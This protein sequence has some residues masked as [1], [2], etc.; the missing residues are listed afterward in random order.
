MSGIM[1]L[2]LGYQPSKWEKESQLTEKEKG[3]LKQNWIDFAQFVDAN[4]SISLKRNTFTIEGKNGSK[5]SFD[6]SME[7][8]IW[9]PPNTLER[10][11]NSLRAIRNGA[12][13]KSNL[14]VHMSISKHQK[15]SKIDT[16]I[17]MIWVL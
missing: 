14:G 10:Y 2:S 16:G 1:L 6:A 3:N 17:R 7:F 5:F 12:R 15:N 13:R 9:L 4:D 11:V 8:S